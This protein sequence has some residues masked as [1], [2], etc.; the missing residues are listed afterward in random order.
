M[1][2]QVGVIDTGD[3]GEDHE[4]EGMLDEAEVLTGPLQELCLDNK[5]FVGSNGRLNKLPDTCYSFWV[6]GSLDVSIRL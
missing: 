3:G 5:Y 4:E 6:N 2:R 1:L